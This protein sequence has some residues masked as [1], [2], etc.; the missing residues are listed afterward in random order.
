MILSLLT[1]GMMLA[2]NLRPVKASV[3]E[4]ALFKNGFAVLF[5]TIDIPASGDYWLEKVPEASLGTLWFTTTGGAKLREVVA[6]SQTKASKPN[7][8]SI[9]Q[10]LAANIGKTVRLGLLAGDAVTTKKVVGKLVSVSHE[11]VMVDTG[12]EV[13]A[14]PGAMITSVAAAS[15]SLNLTQKGQNVTRGLRFKVD[16][17]GKVLMISLERGL[18]WAPNY[19]IDITDPK[20]LRLTAKC[21][22]LNDLE[23]LHDIE[24]RFVTG[25][26]NLPYA[27][28][29]DPLTSAPSVSQFVSTINQIGAPGMGGPGGMAG[30]FGGGGMLTQNAAGRVEARDFA[31]A[32]PSTG[33]GGDEQEDLFFYRQ[34]NVSLKQGDRSYIILFEAKAENYKHLY[35]WDIDDVVQ[36]DVQYQPVAVDQTPD[37][38]HSLKF[39]NNAGQPLTTGVATTY[40]NSELLGQDILKYTSRGDEAEVRITKAMDVRAESNEEET[41]RQRGALQLNNRPVYDLVTLKGTLVMQNLKSE[42]VDVKVTKNLTGEV[43]SSEGDPKVTKTAKRLSAINPHAR[44]E[45]LKTIEPGKTLTLTYQYKVY[46]VQ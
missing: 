19:A 22:I 8:A 40:K 37:V 38:W 24:A 45:W 12:R 23:D 15:G 26:P 36:N 43:L 2:P 3:N 41:D 9:E 7:I 1:A 27:F 31:G 32:M 14:I 39:K 42:P 6:T 16:G 13:V 44:L 11:M 25:F 5:R 21:T 10:L 33:I 30:G 35:T 29:P 17:A 34:P 20:V 28:A 46:V 18:T 4:A